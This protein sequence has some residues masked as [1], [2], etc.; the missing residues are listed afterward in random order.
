MEVDGFD[1]IMKIKTLRRFRESEAMEILQK[2]AK[3]VQPIMSKRKWIVNTLSEFCPTKQ[4]LLGLNTGRGIEVKI[5]LRRPDNELDF[6]PFSQILDTML[7]E[8]CHNEYMPHNTHFYKLLEEIKKESDELMAKEIIETGWIPS[9][10]T[11]DLYGRPLGGFPLQQN[12]LPAAENR[13]VVGGLLPSG[14]MHIGDMNI[15]S[16]LSA[17]QAAVMAAERRLYDEVWCGFE[18]SENEG[19]SKMFED[20]EQFESG[21]STQSSPLGS[22]TSPRTTDLS[23]MW[24]CNTCT[25]LNQPLAL[26]CEA[27]GTPKFGDHGVKSKVWSCKFCTLN[28]SIKVDKCLACGEWRYSS[29]APVTTRGPN[30][31]T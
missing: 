13:T 20:T 26:A 2:I 22:Q 7:H 25:L 30:I 12:A 16:T 31:G 10:T 19:P 18:S 6:L 5:R 24:Q 9:L 28:N 23:S 3:H 8:L 17:T 29:G 11:F 27:C 15:M 4:S 14:T 21:E 1:K